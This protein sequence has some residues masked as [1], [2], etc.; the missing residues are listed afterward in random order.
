MDIEVVTK[1][2]ICDKPNVVICHTHP[3][4]QWQGG[5]YNITR[6]AVTAVT[7]IAAVTEENRGMF[8]YHLHL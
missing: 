8:M 4:N 2:G 7:T 3:P 1:S 6:V 5:C